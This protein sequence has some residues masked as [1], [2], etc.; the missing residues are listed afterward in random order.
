MN[1]YADVWW[2]LFWIVIIAYAVVAAA[3]LLVF[4]PAARLPNEEFDKKIVV[5]DLHSGPGVRH[6][7]Y[8]LEAQRDWLAKMLAWGLIVAAFAFLCFMGATHK[9]S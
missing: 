5:N 7:T 4:S 9:G 6:T 2:A 8:G 1:P 3:G